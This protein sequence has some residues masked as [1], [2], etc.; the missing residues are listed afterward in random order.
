MRQP[1]AYN[2]NDA[3]VWIRRFVEDG[4]STP[5]SQT[6]TVGSLPASQNTIFNARTGKTR[7][8]LLTLKN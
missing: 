6:R 4:M 2:A 3:N 7:E 8:K 1:Y 5:N